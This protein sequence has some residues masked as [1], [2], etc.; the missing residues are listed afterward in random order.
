M[1][2]TVILVISILLQFAAAFCALRLIWVTGKRAAWALIATAIFLM[3]IRRCITLFQVDI[4]NIP[5]TTSM[6]AELVALVISS[7]MLIGVVRITPPFLSLKRSENELRES[8][9]KYRSLFENVP[10]SLWEEDFSVAKA[11]IDDLRGRGI[12]NFR[13]YFENN[14]EDVAHCAEM[15]KIVD[16]NQATLNLY[17][18]E[19]KPDIMKGLGQIFREET[20][21]VFR[22]QLIALAEGRT[23]FESERLTR[24]LKGDDRHVYLALSFAPGYEDTW[25]RVL[26][27]ITDITERKKAEE[28]LR[29]AH[30]ELEMR[31][32]ERTK[33]LR[34]TRDYLDNLF[35]YANA[36]IIVWNPKLE[37]TR[38]N[39][40]FER[41]TGYSADEVLGGKVDILFPD[42]SRDESMKHI[43]E[44]TSGERWEVVEIPIKHKDGTVYILLW[45][46]ATIY[47]PDGKTAVATIAQGQDI[48]ERKK[49]EQL[50]D[51]FIGLVSHELRTPLTVIS[52]S[53]RTAMSEGVSQEDVRE[54]LQ[55]AAE[56]A[57][58]LAV[59]LEN[60]LELSRYQAGRLQLRI[61]PVSIADVV[62]NVTEELKRQGISHQFLIDIPKKLPPV[63]ADPVRVERILFNLMENAAKYSPEDSKIKVSSRTQGGFVVTR[64]IDRGLG[65]S[66]DDQPKIFNLFQQ[67]ETSR[68]LTKGTGLGLVV[69]KRLVE[70]QGGW[71]KV[72]SELGKGSTF[73]F[74][75]PKRRVT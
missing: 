54:L 55:N 74:A 12:E 16:I 71:I 1:D 3:A 21:D 5:Y 63:E 2:I 52:G 75:L 58:S 46:S 44:A 14:P 56:G 48:T 13:D 6:S 70:A 29:K 45:N 25:S 36:P 4:S 41:L 35:N 62:Q 18:A 15:V 64:I 32:H 60:M 51:E 47:A 57:D 59:I 24:T 68:R 10:I 39:Y 23:R 66:L 53:L 37:I 20:Y 11:F 73:S 8:R 9:E 19:G 22:E 69:C 31:V 50:K 43:R 27:S 67:L 65:I 33:E 30:D 17:Q 72:D 28:A 49:V 7:L 26:L 61:E 34:E 38:F 40:A 42:D